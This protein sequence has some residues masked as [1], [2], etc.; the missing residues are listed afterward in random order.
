MISEKTIQ[1][2]RDLD[3]TTVL[4]PYVEL[5]R[6]GSR[7]VGLCPFHSEKTGS[8]NVN[9]NSNLYY[10]FS[11]HRGGDG[12]HFVMEK[13]NCSFMEAI[14]KIAR[15]NNI[16]IDYIGK[17]QSEEYRRNAMKRESLL[18]ALD[19]AQKFF[20]DSLRVEMDEESRVARD[21]AYGRWPQEYCSTSGIGYAP[22]D[23][24]TFLDYCK[25]KGLGTDVLIDSGLVAKDEESGNIY[26]AFRERIMIPIRDRW[27]RIIAFT[28]RYIG[29]Y[30]KTPKYK[31]S[32]NTDIYTKGE[33][34]FGIDKVFRR[35]D[36]DNVIIVEGA[37]DVM[38]FQILGYDNVVASL[39]TAWTE[40]QFRQLKKHYQSICF[41]PDSDVVEGRLYGPGFEAV[42]KNGAEAMRLGFD[43]TVRELPFEQIEITEEELSQMYPEGIP[44]DAVRIRPGK[45]DADSYLKKAEDFTDLTEKDFVVWL[46]EKRFCEADSIQTERNA[47]RE[48]AGLLCQVKDQIVLNQIIAQLTKS[49]GNTKLWRDA[50]TRA[51]N[52]SR[53]VRENV[54]SLSEREKQIEDLRQAGLFIRDN[55]YYTIGNEEED[56]MLLSNFVM[57]PLFHISDESNGVRIFRLKNDAGDSRLLEI[58][59]SELCSLAA[60][61]QKTGTLGNFLWF[62]RIDSLNKVKRYLYSRTDT[63]ERIRKLGWNSEDDIFAFGN[64]I[65]VDGEF[66]KV[67]DMGIVRGADGKAFYI[68]ATSKMYVNNHEIFQFERLMT[69]NETSGVTLNT[70]ATKLIEVF[71]ENARVALCYL[72]ATVYRDVI[73]SKT[74]HFPILNLFGEKGTGKTTLATS[75]QSLFFH[76]IDPPNLSVTSIPAMNDRVSQ[77]VNTLVVFDEY[78]NDLDIRKIGFLK[79]LWGGG[80]Q[81]KKNTASDGVASQ[82]IVSTGIALCGQDKP[83]QDMALFT[84]VIFLAFTKTSFSA[85]ER[86]RYEELTALCNL[87]LTHLT[88]ELMKHRPI[89]ERNFSEAYSMAKKELAAKFA[90]VKVHDRVFGNWVIPLA[91]FRTLETVLD[92]PFSYSELYDTVC[93]GLLNQNELANESSEVG[94]FWNL[95]DGWHSHGKFAEGVH[96]KIKFLKRFRSLS[97]KEDVEFSEAKPILYLN[98]AAIAPLLANRNMSAMSARSYWSTIVSYLKSHTSY[99]GLKQDRF[100][101]LTAN[102]LPDYFYETV[103]GQQVRKTRVIRPKALCFDYQQLKSEFNLDLETETVTDDEAFAED[104]DMSSKNYDTAA[105]RQTDLFVAD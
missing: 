20:F 66:R 81:T 23:S 63:A 18:A 17:E 27:G 56:P 83:T 40:S 105:D 57:E 75:L 101:L 60:F 28:G 59:E 34:L 16:P 78:K 70:F 1:A 49:Y 96:F 54:S 36:A 82:T 64:G 35:R 32:R 50:I 38:R 37:P 10:C 15:D 5:V 53:K 86:K 44:E 85:P 22:K 2:V 14:G 89:F 71:G 84:R 11:C 25:S 88:V 4:K 91:V 76:G 45:N 41:V 6:K 51:R 80:G 92:L 77:A 74:R 26:A 67:D 90:D 13:E 21:Y 47:V 33:T 43:V 31:N 62:A 42:M 24:R 79:G 65:L 19:T 97:M 46:A 58:R 12:I 7:P 68:P 8:F 30:D 104:G 73:F 69:H 94:D 103:N 93:K 48:I 29:S 39:G 72:F 87:G 99:L 95:L 102:G 61:Q 98:T 55:S 100:T 52:E 9:P 3:I